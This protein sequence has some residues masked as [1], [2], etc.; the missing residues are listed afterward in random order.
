MISHE[1]RQSHNTIGLMNITVLQLVE[2]RGPQLHHLRM[3]QTYWDKCLINFSEHPP[4]SILQPLYERQIRRS[5]RFAKVYQIYELGLVTGTQ[6]ER[7]YPHLQ[8]V[9]K[10]F[11]DIEQVNENDRLADPTNKSTTGYSMMA[12]ENSVANKKRGL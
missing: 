3:F 5:E 12:Y 1:L 9:V 11:L 6:T 10:K 7:D 2:C 8:G 4:D